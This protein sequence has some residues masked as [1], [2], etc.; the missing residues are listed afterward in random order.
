MHGGVLHLAATCAHPCTLLY[1]A[2]DS[3]FGSRSRSRSD[4]TDCTKLTL[5]P[6][7]CVA[8][9]CLQLALSIV[10]DIAAGQQPDPESVELVRQ[11]VG[12]S[13]DLQCIPIHVCNFA[14]MAAMHAARP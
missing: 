4:L 6:G 5:L 12:P 9:L 13:L 7:C 14:C 11:A 8:G 10:Q 2:S 3:R 1:I